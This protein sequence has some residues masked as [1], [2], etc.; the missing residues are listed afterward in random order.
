MRDP[1][2]AALPTLLAPWQGATG[3]P[4]GGP[5]GNAK[6]ASQKALDAD[7]WKALQAQ[8]RDAVE[9]ALDAG[10][11][12]NACQNGYP[13]FWIAV[14]QHRYDVAELLV[15]KG[16]DPTAQGRGEAAWA[17]MAPRDDVEEGQ[18]LA[19]LMGSLKEA[20]PSNFLMHQAYR[21]FFWWAQAQPA[22]IPSPIPGLSND[23]AAKNHRDVVLAA[24]RGPDGLLPLLNQRWGID[25]THPYGLT[26]AWG[27]GLAYA[28]WEEIARRDS[29]PLAQRALSHGWGPPRAKDLT[30]H[31]MTLDTAGKR[32]TPLFGSMGWYFL[33]KNAMALFE[34]WMAD[35][36]L[37]AA[38]HDDAQ[39]LP[40]ATLFEV[41]TSRPRLERLASLGVRMDGRDSKGNTL[42]HL[43]ANSPHLSQTMVRWWL[44]HRPDDFR[45]PNVA[46]HTA[47]DQPLSKQAKPKEVS[48][49]RE[50]WL[51]SSL[52]AAPAGV[53]TRSR[54]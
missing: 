49:A 53:G 35:P 38:F 47:L 50:A 28:T 11:N 51:A 30:E 2:T 48:K 22:K 9:A 27:P 10:A 44:Q 46:G 17:A 7:L 15:A 39:R 6:R 16:A 31:A 52:P 43:L 33:S 41:A 32:P 40:G 4:V 12:P 5:E 1:L 14:Q 3:R 18:R 54:L 21:L 34:W 23:W 45:V 26:G 24:L 25:P 13:P 19:R 8:Q 37:A 29:V 20:T 42:L 36:G